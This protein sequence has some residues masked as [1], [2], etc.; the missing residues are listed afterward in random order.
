MA[1]AAGQH[2]FQNKT[3]TLSAHGANT[4]TFFTLPHNT[5]IFIP[6]IPDVV[7]ASCDAECAFARLNFIECDA[8]CSNIDSILNDFFASQQRIGHSH[9]DFSYKIYDTRLNINECPNINYYSEQEKFR[10]G[11][12]ECPAIVRQVYLQNHISKNGKYRQIGDDIEIDNLERKILNFNKTFHELG[13]DSI[14]EMLNAPD[15]VPI[16][17]PGYDRYTFQCGSL[18]NNIIANLLFPYTKRLNS[19][20]SAITQLPDYVTYYHSSKFTTLEKLL[21]EMEQ[22]RDTLTL[23]NVI[24]FYRDKIN[25]SHGKETFITIITTACNKIP[26]D[27]MANYTAKDKG[28]LYKEYIT[29]THFTPEEFSP[30][31]QQDIAAQAASAQ[32]LQSV[33]IINRF[34]G[35]NNGANKTAEEINDFLNK[36]FIKIGIVTDRT[37]DPDRV[38]LY[39]LQIKDSVHPVIID[40]IK[41]HFGLL[42]G[43]INNNNYYLKYL[44]YK[45]K[46]ISFK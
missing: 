42:G 32:V 44:K 2:I 33:V 5:R 30:G 36:L 26:S 22:S 14:E 3:F 28:L 25:L 23:E 21:Y 15:G 38:T 41:R 9:K 16:D 39:I 20:S 7:W 1:G 4:G 6:S 34:F 19:G 24:K 45:K 46:Y 8:V 10:T 18:K 40:F 11:I 27:L 13:F 17:Q 29:S 12:A 43:S 37:F 35:K 31:T